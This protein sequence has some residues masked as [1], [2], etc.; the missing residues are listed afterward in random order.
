MK[1]GAAFAFVASGGV[2]DL[3]YTHTGART[4]EEYG[5]ESIWIGEHVVVP[6]GYRAVYPGSATGRMVVPDDADFPAPLVWL[7]VV[8][9][10]S[11]TVRLGTSTLSARLRNPVLLAKEAATLDRLSGGRLMLGVGLGWMPDEYAAVGVSWDDRGERLD[12]TIAAMRALWSDDETFHGAHAEFTRARC[13]PK[14]V[15]PGGVPVHV[16]GLGHRAA[17]RAGR[18]GDGFLPAVADPDAMRALLTT[19]HRSAAAAGREADTIEVTAVQLPIRDAPGAARA[20]DEISTL[21][22]LGVARVRVSFAGQH[23]RASL[24]SAMQRYAD[25][26]IAKVGAT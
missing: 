14:P 18:I 4:A 5:Y 3:D 22:Q 7:A 23:D 25:E 26:V 6:D 1:F 10:L 16:G 24:R 21:E 9:G 8:S 15:R 13:Y 11:R 2:A 17:A 20:R 19:M 12:E